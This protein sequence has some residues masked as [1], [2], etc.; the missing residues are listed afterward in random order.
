MFAQKVRKLVCLLIL[1]SIFSPE[2]SEIYNRSQEVL[3]TDCFILNQ[4]ILQSTGFFAEFHKVGYDSI[5]NFFLSVYKPL[6]STLQ[7][8]CS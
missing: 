4:V 3:S 8:D 6:K 1:K 2:Q 5:V 7:K